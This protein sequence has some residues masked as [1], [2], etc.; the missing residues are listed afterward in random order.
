MIAFLPLLLVQTTNAAFQTIPQSIDEINNVTYNLE[1]NPKYGNIETVNYSLDF[2][3][4]PEIASINIKTK[5]D[6]PSITENGTENEGHI[7]YELS[8]EDFTIISINNSHYI[9]DF[10][11][12]NTEIL[13]NLANI[14]KDQEFRVDEPVIFTGFF[15]LDLYTSMDISRL[16]AEKLFQYSG[17]VEYNRSLM[18][19]FDVYRYQFIDSWSTGCG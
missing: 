19:T 1:F 17:I 13:F 8:T 9:D 7:E 15:E 2:V 16:K 5:Y 11:G 18:Q 3:H 10:V 6:K 4:S 14:G 12:F